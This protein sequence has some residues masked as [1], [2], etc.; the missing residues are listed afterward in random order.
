[1]ITN[2]VEKENTVMSQM[3]QYL[4]TWLIMYSMIGILKICMI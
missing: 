3:E 1:M 4:V 2:K